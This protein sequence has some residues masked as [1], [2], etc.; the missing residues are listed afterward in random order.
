[1]K[2]E[3]VNTTP[4]TGIHPLVIGIIGVAALAGS[5]YLSVPLYP[6]PVTLQTLV[7]LMVGALAGPWMGATIVLAWLGLSMAGLPLLADGK[8]GLM[9]F[10]GPTGGYLASFPLVAYLAGY[11][12]TGG[13]IRSLALGLAGFL[14]LHALVLACGWLWLSHFVGMHSAFV[15]GVLPFLAG[16]AL[17]SGLATGLLA[18]WKDT[19]K[20]EHAH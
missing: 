7:V 15:N 8:A 1:M 4:K 17:K 10:T 2:S 6:V 9:A 16:S 19:D 13:R 20:T 14:A 5:S 12:P 3:T 11:L 18:A